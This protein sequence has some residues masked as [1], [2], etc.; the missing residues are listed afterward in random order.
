MALKI[1]IA[2]THSTGKTTLLQ[3]VADTLQ[4]LG[5]TVARVS[6]LAVEARGHGF[7]ILRDHTF[8]STLWIMARGIT[9]EL[10]ATLRAD[11]VMVDR[12][13]PDAMGYLVAALKYRGSHLK[14][15]ELDYLQML[16]KHHAATY[17]RIFKTMI[18]QSKP[19]DGN[20]Q[21]D[22]DPRFREEV[23]VALDQVFS[24]L[25]IPVNFLDQ[26]PNTAATQVLQQTR[27]LLSEIGPK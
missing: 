26:N 21:R 16:V 4:G 10:E 20:K 1:A 24:E 11:V 23:D 5:Y 27:M 15:P 9:L 13:V 12:P 2:G 25:E 22:M 17:G 8:A 7:P 18:D 14:Q 6:D 19:I 3:G